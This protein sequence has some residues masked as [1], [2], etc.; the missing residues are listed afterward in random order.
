MLGSVF[1]VSV[2]I[3]DTKR[4]VRVLPRQVSMDT[5]IHGGDAHG[6]VGPL[7]CCL[8]LVAAAT[9]WNST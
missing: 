5:W 3:H 6:S 4:D 9:T 2:C 1:D 8:L 7:V